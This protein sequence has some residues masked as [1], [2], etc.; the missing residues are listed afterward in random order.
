MH[1][2]L[3]RSASAGSVL[4]QYFAVNAENGRSCKCEEELWILHAVLGTLLAAAYSESEAFLQPP[5]SE[6]QPPVGTRA[7]PL[8][9]ALALWTAARPGPA[10]GVGWA[11]CLSAQVLG[12][13]ALVSVR[14]PRRHGAR[15]RAGGA[16]RPGT[17]GSSAPATGLPPSS[18][19]PALAL[20]R[21][22]SACGFKGRR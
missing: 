17:R 20:G 19:L 1:A 10:A 11:R 9:A 8:L 7:P 12:C 16:R 3:R 6:L 13:L 21:S 4:S 15:G 14:P 18:A 22:Q 5:G 2:S